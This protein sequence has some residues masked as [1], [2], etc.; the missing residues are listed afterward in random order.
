MSEGIRLITGLI[1]VFIAVLYIV[2]IRI[3][4]GKRGMV[5]KGELLKPVPEHGTVARYRHRVHPCRCSRCKEA[6]NDYIRN[7]RKNQPKNGGRNAK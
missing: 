3:H 2:M 5:A 7:Y 4:E 6:W 1:I